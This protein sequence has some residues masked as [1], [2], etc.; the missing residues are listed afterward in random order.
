M[1]AGDKTVRVFPLAL[2][3][4]PGIGTAGRIGLNDENNTAC[5][6]LS[7]ATES[8]TMFS[9]IVFDWS[10][11]RRS[12]PVEWRQLTVTRAGEI[13]PSG[14]AAYRLQVGKLH[15]AMYRALSGTERYR[16]FLGYQVESETVIGHFTKSGEIQE[17]LIVE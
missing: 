7:H 3:Q 8:G 2:P 1:K 11:K 12:V 13:D 16:T 4:D 14:A 15:L 10:S 17:I 6:T 5:L 9:P